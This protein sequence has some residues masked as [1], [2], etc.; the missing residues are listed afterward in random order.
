MTGRGADEDGGIIQSPSWPPD[1][2]HIAR[3]ETGQNQNHNHY[4]AK[5]DEVFLQLL[6]PF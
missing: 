6:S 5:Y 4:L 1:I 2:R 3:C